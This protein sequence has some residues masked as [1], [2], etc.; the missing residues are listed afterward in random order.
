MGNNDVG[1]D[2]T[3]VSVWITVLADIM[4]AI[5]TTVSAEPT[6]SSD[7]TDMQLQLRDLQKQLLLQKNKFKN[8]RYNFNFCKCNRI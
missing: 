5:G 4:A 3:N 2:L 8:S 1:K 6:N 7:A